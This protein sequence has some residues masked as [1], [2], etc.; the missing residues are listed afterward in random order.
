MVPLQLING[1]V[2][3]LYLDSS[4]YQKAYVQ[5]HQTKNLNCVLHAQ[6]IPDQ[7]KLVYKSENIQSKECRDR[8]RGVGLLLAGILVDNIGRETDKDIASR[9]VSVATSGNSGIVLHLKSQHG[10]GLR[11]RN[12]NKGPHPFRTRPEGHLFSRGGR[13]IRSV[14]L[15]LVKTTF[16]GLICATTRASEEGRPLRLERNFGGLLLL[17]ERVCSAGDLLVFKF[18]GQ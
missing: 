14:T 5:A 9:G 16:E 8:G 6:S 13:C 7:D 4:I 3:L 17:L 2:E 15:S 11:H 12:K 1:F 18:G 10:C